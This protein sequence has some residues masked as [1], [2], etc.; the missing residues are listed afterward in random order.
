MRLVIPSPRALSEI[1]R[2]CSDDTYASLY[3]ASAA[4]LMPPSLRQRSTSSSSSVN[5]ANG[6]MEDL[7]PRQVRAHS[8]SAI[9]PTIPGCGTSVSFPSYHHHQSH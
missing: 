4:S 6:E 8:I 2:S 9:Y 3:S 1:G 5:G 7:L